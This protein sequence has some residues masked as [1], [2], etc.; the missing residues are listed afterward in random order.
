VDPAQIPVFILAGGLGTRMKEETEFRPKPMVQLG[1]HPILWHVMKC[2]SQHGF[3]RFII[4]AGFKAEVIK[5][6][7]LNYAAMRGDFTVQL[8][9]DSVKFHPFNPSMGSSPRNQ[10]LS[11]NDDE[12]WEVTVAFT[13]ETAMTGA[14]VARACERYLGD[15]KTFAVTYG[16]GLTNANLRAELEFH[17]SHGKTGTVMGHNPPSRFGQFKLSG[18]QVTEFVE[19]PDLKDNWINA[20]FFF[21]NR[22]FQ[23]MLSTSDDCILERAP[24]A[25][26]AK[27]GQLQIFRHEGFWASADTQRDLDHLVGLWKS[28]DAPWANP[29]S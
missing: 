19:K 18:T 20:G 27:S 15:A 26:L 7:F 10:F 28:G 9:T 6:Y 23:K 13:G 12:D 4:C 25:N 24:L 14:R 3:R 8:K 17:A 29:V 11:G 5:S 16:D 22:E 2:Y 21:F 1:S